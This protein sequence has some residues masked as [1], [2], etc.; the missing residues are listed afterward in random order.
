MA[1]VIPFARRLR[2]AASAVGSSDRQSGIVPSL[3]SYLVDELAMPSRFAALDR[4]QEITRQRAFTLQGD[5]LA[6]LDR[7]AKYTVRPTFVAD[8]PDARI[9][10][11]GHGNEALLMTDDNR[12]ILESSYDLEQLQASPLYGARLPRARKLKGRHI[13]VPTLWFN[14]HFHWVTDLLPRFSLLDAA[15]VGDD[16][17]IV[18]P[19][20][21][22]SGQF[23]SLAMMGIDRQRLQCFTGMHWQIDEAIF[24]S[25]CSGTGNP[26]P[27]AMRWLR[28]R[29]APPSLGPTDRRIWVTRGTG[30]QRR[31]SNEPELE[32]VLADF[33]FK[34]IDPGGLTFAEQMSTFSEAA[35][36]A[37]PHGAG[38][39]GMVA[40]RDATVV[41]VFDPRYVNACFYAL[42]AALGHRYSYLAGEPDTNDGVTVNPERLVAL[43][44]E[45]IGHAS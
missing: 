7:H 8:I 15:G 45:V 1:A 13:V 44:G 24:P 25:L 3:E 31:I 17:P 23:E 9:V 27:T 42:A 6:E 10:S 5:E 36:I 38:L 18:L 40:A 4:G 33:G 29:L 39:T 20:P 16:L 19:G 35:I 43:L 32:S 11:N 14:N 37:G 41:E 12:L 26:S 28:E 30:A 2:E 34:T 22:S 21:L